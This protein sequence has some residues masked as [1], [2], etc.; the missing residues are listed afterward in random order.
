M[1]CFLDSVKLEMGFARR[2]RN[3]AGEKSLIGSI[4]V[5]QDYLDVLLWHD[6]PPSSFHTLIGTGAVEDA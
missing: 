2:S 4:M 1:P 6:S 3:T 5:W